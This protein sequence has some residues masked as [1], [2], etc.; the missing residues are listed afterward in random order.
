MHYLLSLLHHLDYEH[1]FEASA[2]FQEM[3][4]SV[5]RFDNHFQPTPVH[6]QS[7]LFNKLRAACEFSWQIALQSLSYCTAFF[8]KRADVPASTNQRNGK[9]NHVVKSAFDLIE[10]LVHF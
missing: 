10:K 3:N 1:S 8:S 9:L 6:V 7:L 4:Q 5:S 2:A